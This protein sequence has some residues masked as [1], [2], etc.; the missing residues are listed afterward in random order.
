MSKAKEILEGLNEES[1]VKKDIEGALKALKSAEGSLYH[2]A[3][4]GDNKELSRIH[5]AVDKAY[6]DLIKLNKT[7]K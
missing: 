6:L 7:I 2:A 3:D 4:D 1:T 5:K